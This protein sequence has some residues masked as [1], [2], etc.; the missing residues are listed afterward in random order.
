MKN[1][2]FILA[3]LFVGGVFAQS[4]I[5]GSTELVFE[6]Q[7][8]PFYHGVA[9]GDPTSSSVI[10]WTR[11]TPDI[12]AVQT[13]NW[14]V[15]TDTAMQ[16]VVATGTAT[17]DLT[18]DYTLKVDVTGLSAQTTYYYYFQSNNAYSII[19]RTRT[20]P[21]STSE[22]LKFA[23]VSCSNYE[24]GYFNVYERIS[25]RNDIDAVIHLGDYIYEYD[26]STYSNNI[27]NRANVPVH[28]IVEIDDYRTRYSLYRL[29]PKL[30][31]VHQQ[32]PFMCIWDDHETANDAYVGGAQNHN[33]SNEYKPGQFEGDWSNRK[34]AAKSA[35]LEWMPIRESQS[36]IY[37]KAQ[38]GDLAEIWL[39][40]T[41]I[42]GREEQPAD[43]ISAA[44]SYRTILGQTQR[45]WLINGL[46]NSTSK[47]KVV[48][49]Q[50]IFSPLNVGFA[51]GFGDGVPDPTNIDSVT[52]VESIFMDIWDGY[53]QE[54]SLI[55]DSIEANGI[56]NIIILSGDFHS[57]FAFDVTDTPCA[58]PNPAVFNLP[59]PNATY[60]P[61]NGSGSKAVEFVTPSVTSAN[62]DENVG[63]IASAQFELSFNSNLPTGN[64]L[65]PTVNYNPH[66]K[67]TDLDQHGYFVLDLKADSAQADWY[68]VNS[69]LDQNDT[70]QAYGKGYYTV[71]GGNHL[72]YAPNA[73]APKPQQEIPAPTGPFAAVS[74][75]EF[76]IESL[77]LGIYPN[78]AKDKATLQ[79]AINTP[80]NIE[81]CLLTFD[82]KTVQGV[83]NKYHE[84]GIYQYSFDTSNL[85]AGTYQI[86]IK[87]AQRT[88]TGKIL[89]IE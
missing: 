44:A 21:S 27:T 38:Y 19:G 79:Y 57:T 1:L 65:L 37:R 36:T 35:Y 88:S 16:N 81:I 12:D 32:Q 77:V 48:A 43:V 72:T 47:W 55:L 17:T 20:T 85:A 45:N 49:N 25:E 14:K 15:C 54:R 52:A 13:V 78:P 46:K 58:Y 10:I 66:M 28:E 40:D 76:N 51:A 53:P 63:P 71:D 75:N 34:Q 31:S 74:L 83:I 73:A 64:P 86:S 69:I 80:G 2:L 39:L 4:P 8:A 50:V 70:I 5:G 11:I 22:N 6:P 67:Y 29:D 24:H 84:V 33:P 26:T 41:R 87:S 18:K 60:N 3:S 61:A 23:V 56:D 62:F 59:T 30:R 42:E 89:I 82:G 7:L 68:F 9:S